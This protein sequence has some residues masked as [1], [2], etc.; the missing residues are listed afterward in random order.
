MY[1]DAC[2]RKICEYEELEAEES[3]KEK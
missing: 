1:E 3:K 2:G